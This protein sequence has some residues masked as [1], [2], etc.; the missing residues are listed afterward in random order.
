MHEL[1]RAFVRL[2]GLFDAVEPT[3][4]L[5]PRGVQIVVLVEG[6]AVDEGDGR[7]RLSGLGDCR[8]MVELDDR[9]TRP[10]RK[11]AVER[12]ELRPILGLV[13]VERRD[14]GLECIKTAA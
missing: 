5:S 8:G 12:S 14:R 11:L 7:C 6:E 13:G 9:G 4:K 10:A 2:T 3:Q 1:E